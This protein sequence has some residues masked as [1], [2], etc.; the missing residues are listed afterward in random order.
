MDAL[1]I[2]DRGD[3]TP[4][5][6]RGDWAGDFGQTQFLPSSYLQVRGRLRR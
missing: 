4:A 2:V 6:M 1:R 3:L 5:E